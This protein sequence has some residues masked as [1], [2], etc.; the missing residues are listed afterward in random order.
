LRLGYQPK[1]LYIESLA[2]SQPH[3]EKFISKRTLESL[4]LGLPNE[5]IFIFILIGPYLTKGI[6]VELYNGKI[7]LFCP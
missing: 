5:K 1:T 3:N 7:Y 4:K 2:S 6:K